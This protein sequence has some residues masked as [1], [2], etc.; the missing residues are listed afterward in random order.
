MRKLTLAEIE[1]VQRLG[2]TAEDWSKILVTED[3]SPEQLQ[4]SRLGGVIEL[5]SGAHIIRSYVANYRI[6]ARTVVEQITALQCRESSTFGG[7]VEVATMNECEGRKVKICD[8]M[9]AQV[10][11]MMALYRH[12]PTLIEKLEALVE[13]EAEAHRDTLGTVGEDCSISGARFLREVRIGNRV[14]IDGSSAL[15]NGTILDDATVGV[16]VKAYNFILCEG[17]KVANGVTIER[18]FIGESCILDKGFTAAESLFFANSHC[19]N[20]EAASIFA[21]PY[22]VSHHK[23]SL[24]IAGMFSFFNAGSGSN[25]SN[26]L[27]K[28]GAVHQA[29]HPRGCKFASGA[30]IMAPALEGAFTMVMGHHSRHH[31]ISAFPYSYLLEKEE[32]SFLLPAVN[33]TSYGTVR[34]IEK[35]PKRDKRRVMRDVINFEEHNPYTTGSMLHAVDML[36]SIEEMNPDSPIYTYNRVQIRAAAL[37]RG[38]TL[39]NRAIVASLGA[40]LERGASTERYNGAGRWLDMAGQYI[41]KQAADRIVEEIEQEKLDSLQ[42]IDN[43]FRVFAVHYDDY[44]HSWAEQV[45]ASL[46]GHAPSIEEVREAIEAGRNARESIRRMTDADRTRDCG[47]DMAVS[48]GLDCDSMEERMADFRTVRGLK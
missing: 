47:A 29:V 48:Y 42:A 9:S 24:L 27:F 44:A 32:R 39:Y 34:D 30:Y 15:V 43:A 18:C 36:H 20:G 22:T 23:S 21:G 2:T 13:K 14:T 16:D 5:G 37:Q 38:L 10:A 7:G 35:W 17:A 1:A 11:Y 31:D 28:S 45:Y 25:Q 3:F 26:H 4:Q 40:M 12:R 33:L 41:A 8:R 6:G 46:L 19:E